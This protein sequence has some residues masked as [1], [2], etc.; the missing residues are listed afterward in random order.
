MPPFD[1]NTSFS[2]KGR[3]KKAHRFPRYYGIG[4]NHGPYQD[5]TYQP[6]KVI[7]ERTS[8]FTFW[9]FVLYLIIFFAGFLVGYFAFAFKRRPA[10]QS[11]YSKYPSAL[12]GDSDVF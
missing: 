12:L 3:N 11:Y 4:P 5:I 6:A 2:H 7:V 8:C 1:V 9:T 10:E